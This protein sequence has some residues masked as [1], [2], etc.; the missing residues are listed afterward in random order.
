MFQKYEDNALVIGRFQPF[1]NGHLEVI[2]KVVAECEC[3][4]IGI[5]SAQYSHISDNPFTAGERYLMISEMLK[6]ECIVNALIVP[7][8]DLNRH[9]LWVSHVESMCPPFSVVYSNN[10]I[11]RRLF[12]E[13]GYKVKALPLYN[14]SIFSGTEVRRRL[15]KNKDWEPLVPKSV[16]KIIKDI[17]GHGRM[18][19][20]MGDFSDNIK[21]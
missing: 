1:H 13:A 7:I 5:G 12:G 19:E 21:S 4:I 6:D 15:I 16:V 11:T 3:V 10:N 18:K 9:S 14:R 2:K 20:I 17:D 8:E